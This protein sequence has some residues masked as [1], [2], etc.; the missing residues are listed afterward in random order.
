VR[1]NELIESKDDDDLFGHSRINWVELVATALV[2]MGRQAQHYLKI[3]DPVGDVSARTDM[4]IAMKEI[5][6][7]GR[8]LQSGGIPAFID[9]MNGM[10][11][12]T[13]DSVDA[14]MAEHGVFLSD[15]EQAFGYHDHL[16]ENDADD[17]LFGTPSFNVKQAAEL[18]ATTGATSGEIIDPE[19]VHRALEHAA[20]RVL[21]AGVIQKKAA[22]Q[23]QKWLALE[24]EAKWEL[25]DQVANAVYDINGDGWE[26]EETIYESNSDDDMFGQGLNNRIA[27][28]L[29]KEADRALEMGEEERQLGGEEAGEAFVEEGRKFGAVAA[30]FEH[31]MIMGVR[32]YLSLDRIWR[33]EVHN[34]VV[35]DINLDLDGHIRKSG[36]AKQ[37]LNTLGINENDDDDLFST[38]AKLDRRQKLKGK[39]IRRIEKRDE[40]NIQPGTRILVKWDN[41][42]Y[43]KGVVDRLT[44]G[45]RLVVQVKFPNVDWPLEKNISPHQVRPEHILSETNDDDDELFGKNTIADRVKGLLRHKQI[46]RIMVPGAMGYVRDVSNGATMISRSLSSTTYVYTGLHS[47]RA[48]D[49]KMIKNHSAGTWDV[50]EREQAENYKE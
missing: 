22:D 37:A 46:V 14:Y 7:L 18:I 35:A 36:L 12:N 24:D 31:S 2:R 41:G 3:S 27:V 45:G 25:V 30:A 11:R 38:S 13:I 15:L 19:G 40:L 1:Y 43:Y 26:P 28:A 10:S 44:R 32:A 17:E 33:D 23:L 49:L 21:N 42:R 20:N 6:Q 34:A 48:Q 8:A 9:A 16:N 50:V 39:S 5:A 29:Q 4:R 47:S